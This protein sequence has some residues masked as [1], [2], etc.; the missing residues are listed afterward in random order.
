MILQ[1]VNPTD[2]GKLARNHGFGTQLET[3]PIVSISL[4]SFTLTPT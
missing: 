1:Q 2:E 3:E 4:A